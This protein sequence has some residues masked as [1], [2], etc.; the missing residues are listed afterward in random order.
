MAR[1]RS[2]LDRPHDHLQLAAAAHARITSSEEPAP[3]D[4]AAPAPVAEPTEQSRRSK[5]QRRN[6]EGKFA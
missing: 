1:R 2:F 3:Q 6:A 5:S 4:V